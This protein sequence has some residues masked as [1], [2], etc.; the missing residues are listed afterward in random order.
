[1]GGEKL[2][3]FP[4]VLLWGGG[5]GSDY[6]RF[7]ILVRTKRK[8]EK[9]FSIKSVLPCCQTNISILAILEISGCGSA[10]HGHTVGVINDDTRE[11]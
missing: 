1:M 4:N 9:L 8:S 7:S 11:S 6:F 2:P 3:S 10:P 5:R